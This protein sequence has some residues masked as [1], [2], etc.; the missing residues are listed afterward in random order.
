M[1]DF[2]SLPRLKA[3]LRFTLAAYLSPPFRDELEDLGVD[4]GL[5]SEVLRLVDSL[6]RSLGKFE[7]DAAEA[8][9]E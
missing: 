7:P 2:E 4:P 5:L 1:P 3:V 9:P 6:E 8:A